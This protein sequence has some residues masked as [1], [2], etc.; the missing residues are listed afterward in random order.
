MFKLKLQHE[1]Y[2]RE[3]EEKVRQARE[4]GKHEGLKQ[5]S[6]MCGAETGLV[7]TLQDE[8][9]VLEQ[10]LAKVWILRVLFF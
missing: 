3:M 9:R 4:Q 10:Q 6:V 8:K 2:Q 7:K 1:Q 5:A